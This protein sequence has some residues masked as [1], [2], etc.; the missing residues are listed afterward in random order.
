[1]L[2][3][4]L[5]SAQ[6]QVLSTEPVVNVTVVN[7]EEDDEKKGQCLFAN[8]IPVDRFYDFVEFSQFRGNNTVVEEAASN[9]YSLWLEYVLC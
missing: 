8:S 6:Q 3:S 4:S 7:G 9:L 2:N 5:G 1:M